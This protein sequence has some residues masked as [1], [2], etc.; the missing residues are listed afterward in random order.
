M[1]C[2]GC[3]GKKFNISRINSVAINSMIAI[4]FKHYKATT[5]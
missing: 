1:V 3:K 5:K 4:E 2:I